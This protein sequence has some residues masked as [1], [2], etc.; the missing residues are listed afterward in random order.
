[1]FLSRYAARTATA[2]FVLLIALGLAWELWLAPLRPGGSWL[3]LKVLPL[4]LALPGIHHARPSSLKLWSMM[5]LAYLC[6]GLVRAVSDHG[7]SAQLAMLET[8][9]SALAFGA[10]L[11]SVKRLL[12]QRSAAAA[13]GASPAA[14]PPM[15][16]DLPR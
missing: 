9:L 4:L 7:L 2:C 11:L 15:T 12:Q 10:I 3:V 13:A 14:A 6:E 5:I 1:M 16:P 8:T